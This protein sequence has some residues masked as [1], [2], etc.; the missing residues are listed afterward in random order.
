MEYLIILRG[1]AGSGKHTIGKSLVEKLEGK[2]QA[3]MQM[4]CSY[5][6]LFY[7]SSYNVKQHWMARSEA[8]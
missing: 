5:P 4:A 1:S 6:Y 8:I 2:S 7:S 3:C